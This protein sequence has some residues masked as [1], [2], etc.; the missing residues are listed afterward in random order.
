M[1][2]CTTAILFSL[3][4]SVHG[5]TSPILRTE[6]KEESNRLRL[7]VTFK[8][9]SPDPEI[10]DR[11]LRSALED[12]SRKRSDRDIVGFALRGRIGLGGIPTSVHYSCPLVFSAWQKRIITADEWRGAAVSEVD[13]G[14][15]LLR[16]SAEGTLPA[17]EP[18]RPFLVLTI[19]FP[20][21]PG[22]DEMRSAALA[23]IQRYADQGMEINVAPRVGNKRV[24]TTWD[25]IFHGDGRSYHFRFN[26]KDRVVYDDQNVPVQTLR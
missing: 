10:V 3:A 25:P 4:V 21:K 14:R 19:V 1:I 13:R 5:E 7:E 8:E 18:M 9:P 6:L 17:P 15:Y 26:P 11:L 23:E 22:V 20:T 2:R 24:R 16:I 12:V